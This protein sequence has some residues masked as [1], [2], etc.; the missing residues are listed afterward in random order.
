[1]TILRRIV[2]LAVFVAV[3]VLGWRFAGDNSTLVVVNYIAGQFEGVALWLVMVVSFGLGACLVG[4]YSAFGRARAGLITRRYRKT[5]AGLE[6]EVHQ[7]RNLPLSP[8][9]ELAPEVLAEPELA[10]GGGD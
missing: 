4:L 2:M 5:V 6:A 1:V 8:D 10:S 7:L 9:A 3:L